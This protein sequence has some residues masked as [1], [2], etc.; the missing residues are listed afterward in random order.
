M[1]GNQAAPCTMLY[2][3]VYKT[4]CLSEELLVFGYMI[5][6]VLA[7]DWHGLITVW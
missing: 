2:H 5:R 7:D 4:V 6:A 3:N 1:K